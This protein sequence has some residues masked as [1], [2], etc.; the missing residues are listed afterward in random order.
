MLIAGNCLPLKKHMQP[1]PLIIL[2]I[3]QLHWKCSFLFK[4]T[5][6][7]AASAAIGVVERAGR[8]GRFIKKPK[9]GKSA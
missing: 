9:S 3:V 2:F 6:F 7:Q 5:I 1:R 4:K 8:E